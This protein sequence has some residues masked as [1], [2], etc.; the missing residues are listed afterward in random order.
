[1]KKTSFWKCVALYWAGILALAILFATSKNVL[2]QT[3]IVFIV[4]V[5]NAALHAIGNNT[6]DASEEP[7][8]SKIR[9]MKLGSWGCDLTTGT[10][11]AL[12]ALITHLVV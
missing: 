2:A 9:I 8:T 6:V 4:F 7:P 1:M 10:I 12:S 3:S 11:F 5:L